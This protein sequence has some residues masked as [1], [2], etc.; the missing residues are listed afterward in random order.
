MEMTMDENEIRKR[1]Y[2]YIVETFLFGEEEEG[3][4]DEGSFLDTGLIDSTGILELIGFLEDTFDIEVEDEEMIPE[5][6]DSVA[7]ATKYV[8]SKLG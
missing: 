3:W 1:V 6:L 4:N 7:R 8:L 2:E 5:N